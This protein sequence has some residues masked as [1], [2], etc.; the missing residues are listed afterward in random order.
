M[1]GVLVSDPFNTELFTIYGYIPV[2]LEWGTALMS[3]ASTRFTG[4][5]SRILDWGEISGLSG[6]DSNPSIVFSCISR[7]RIIYI[8]LFNWSIVPN[9]INFAAL[10]LNLF[11]REMM[12]FINSTEEHCLREVERI[13]LAYHKPGLFSNNSWAKFKVVCVFVV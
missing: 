12:A 3:C 9:Y 2:Q 1:L 13:G 4:T 11:G 8:S 5:S 6:R 10:E 7:C